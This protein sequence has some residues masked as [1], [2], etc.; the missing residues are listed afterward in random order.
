MLVEADRVLFV[1]TQNNRV[2]ALS[3]TGPALVSTVYG[4]GN[5]TDDPHDAQHTWLPRALVPW[6]GG[7]AVSDFGSRRVLWF[8]PA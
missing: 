4:D 1:D 2:R 3:L 5:A 6:N 7:Y 8:E